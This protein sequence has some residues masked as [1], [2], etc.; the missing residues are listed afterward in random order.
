MVLRESNLG[1]SVTGVCPTFTSQGKKYKKALS[2]IQSLSLEDQEARVKK[3]EDV[4][5]KLANLE[6]LIERFRDILSSVIE[7]S[8]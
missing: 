7:V 1:R 8:S 6:F 4:D 2:V 3:S 5:K